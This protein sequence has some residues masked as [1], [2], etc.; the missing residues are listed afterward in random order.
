[1]TVVD[2]TQWYSPTSGGIRTYLHQKAL[3][4]QRAG[5]GHAVVVPGIRDGREMVGAT[6]F[7]RVRGHTPARGWGYRLILSARRVLRALEELGPTVI[8]VHDAMAFPRSI[9]RWAAAR[10]VPMA[11]LCH[12]DLALAAAGLPPALRGMAA[13]TLG[14]T[15]RR[16]LATPGL[17]LVASRVSR[18]RVAP[19]TD[20]RVVVSPL[21]VDV[22][23]FRAARPDPQ[24]RA[25]FA[26]PGHAM[27]LY[28]GRVSSEKRVDLLPEVMAQVA[29]PSVL[30]IA[31]TGA[32]QDKLRRIAVRAGVARRVHMLGH[33]DDRGRLATLMATADCFVH[34]NPNEPFGLCPMEALAAR[35][36]VVVPAGSGT[37]EV[38]EGRGAVVVPPG[39]ARALA[40][41]VGHALTCER[42]DDDLADLSWTRTFARE[43]SAY[44]A[45][46]R[47]AACA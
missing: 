18:D 41:G 15:Q 17:V 1:M 45:L 38:L 13:A 12:S 24:L 10:G 34:P 30:V 19:H 3:W 39:D 28:A 47:A 14:A 8:V 40:H 23:A 9:A 20:A 25:R 31:G 4:A 46:E 21:G 22:A 36:R 43:W 2:I 42:P 26:P 11:M 16:A 7:L 32:A 27:L 5:M 6:P 35:C 44:A 33:V 37:A 29:A